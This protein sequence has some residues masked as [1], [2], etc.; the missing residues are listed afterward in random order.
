MPQSD[1]RAYEVL[2]RDSERALKDASNV[3]GPAAA[4]EAAVARG[5]QELASLRAAETESSDGYAEIKVSADRMAAVGSFYPPVGAGKPV[6]FLG[7]QELA[8]A[9]GLRFGID[10]DAVKSSILEC[11][12]SRQALIGVEIARGRK[13][14][15]EIPARLEL[16]QSLVKKETAQTEARTVDFKAISAF[17][18]VRKGDILA[19]ITPRTEGIAGIDVTGAVV[20]YGKGETASPKPGKNTV[21]ERGTVVAQVDG[22][23]VS[24]EESFWVSEV[25]EILG[26]VDYSTGHIDFPGDVVIGGQIKQGFKV[27][28]GGSLTCAKLIDATEVVCGGD[29]ETAQGILGRM[30]GTVKVGGKVNAKFIENCYLEAGGDVLVATGCLNSVIYTHGSVSTG[31][32][33]VIIGGKVYAQQGVSAFQIGSLAGVRTE[34]H[35]GMDYHVQ[36][37]LV[38]IR[39]R[40]IELALKLKEVETNLTT[41]GQD[42]RLLE[43]RDKL[44]R[45]IRTMNES[46]KSMVGSLH[47]NEDAAVTARGEVHHGVFVEICHVPLV[48]EHPMAKVRLVLDKAFGTVSPERLAKL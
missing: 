39:D 40:N 47:K 24:N 34:I 46:A 36:Q 21:V 41:K 15:D 19:R 3:Q 5:K 43:L 2:I 9:K 13:P 37:K 42:P 38:W 31:P 12:T 18:L 32:K 33:G 28:A 35:C 29:L 45:A 26:D 23:F 6:E 48:V 44:R 27:K 11:N 1:E 17:R 22:R 10:W 16:E 14:S 8:I 30:Q 25:L 4:A 7:V 20:A